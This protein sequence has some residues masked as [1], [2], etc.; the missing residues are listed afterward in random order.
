[1]PKL[2]KAILLAAIAFSTA[3]SGA[4]VNLAATIRDFNNSD[5]SF[6][7]PRLTNG[8]CPGT[9]YVQPILGPNRK[10][11]PTGLID[12]SCVLGDSSR[13]ANYWFTTDPTF[14][15]SA[16]TCIDIPMQVDTAGT[17]TYRNPYFFP[18]DTFDTLP[19]GSPNTFNVKSRGDDGKQHNFSFCME[20][21]G[22]FDARAGQTF[23]FLGDDDVWFFINNRLV[24]DL[25]GVHRAE[26]SSVSLDTLGLTPGL[27]YPWDFFFCER[28]TTGSDILINTSM[29][30]RTTSNFTVE[31]SL[32]G[33]AHHIYSL[34]VDQSNASSCVASN[35]HAPGTGQFTLTG[36]NLTAAKTLNPGTWYGGGIV[37]AK[38]LASVSLDSSLIAGLAPGDYVLHIYEQG[39]TKSFKDIPF[40]VPAVVRTLV[41]TDSTGSDLTPPEIVADVYQAVPI[42]IE[43][44]KDGAFCTTCRDSVVLATDN[45]NLRI[46]SSPTGAA[47][48][49][50]RLNGGKAKV[51]VTSGLP[52][53][54]ARV[55][56]ASDSSASAIRWPV[57]V[58]PPLMVFVDAAGNVL[59]PVPAL[60]IPLGSDAAITVEL[61]TSSGLCFACSDSLVLVAST[62]RLLFSDPS[63]KS[64]TRFLL[65]G[66]K[67]TFH[68]SGWAPAQSAAISVATDHLGAA[69]YWSPISVSLGAISGILTDSDA[70]GRADRLELTL[71]ADASVFSGVVVRWPAADG[72]LDVRRVPISA[73][74][75]SIS[76]PIP[77]FAF[78]STSCPASGCTDLGQ[79]SISR[80]SDTVLVPFPVLDGVDPIPV[81]AEYRYCAT[82]L[83]PDTLVATFSEP[84]VSRSASDPWVSTGHPRQD[85]LGIALS[86]L[87]PPTLLG[88]KVAFFLV[89]SGNRI[90]FDDSLRLSARPSGALSD[91]SGNSPGK[92]AWWTPILWGRPPAMLTV[93]LPHPVLQLGDVSVP[94]D[95]PAIT[96]MIHPNLAHPAQWTPVP[97]SPVVPDTARLG[98]VV[99]HLNRV[100]ENLGMYVYDNLGVLVLRQ[101][102]PKLADLISAGI[103]QRDRRGN[104]EIWLGWNG[105]DAQG[106]NAASGAYLIRIFGWLRDGT[107]LYFLNEIRTSG[108]HR[109]SK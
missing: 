47:I 46:L 92:L 71:P 75:R 66:G 104:Y 86:P 44:F 27:S 87:A 69:A 31:D 102:L 19:D 105:K 35:T 58:R 42:Y 82:G 3:A 28:H 97:G 8:G 93:D 62:N 107:R 108:I 34:W 20:M 13:M 59:S 98:G 50:V 24:V 6:N 76:L 84:V 14:T 79:L 72:S 52:V 101:D 18:I 78:A 57:T 56:A 26:S 51:W 60:D 54:S 12:Q 33:A 37:V 94:P 4:A 67:A 65:K 85:S 106:R 89:D 74:G 64:I 5:S 53:D 36:G 41:F 63:G 45:A 49:S 81:Q 43:A 17:Y 16:A 22:T 40:V 77:P 68:L 11:V 1:M 9:G 2:P 88:R 29:N 30:L 90:Q 21:H 96:V 25:G 15:N 83:T 38:N 91:S 32:L 61:F 7:N 39:S 10:P 109:T 95:E 23:S 103:L 99:V 55:V 100:P 73:T 80:G 48:Q 70:D